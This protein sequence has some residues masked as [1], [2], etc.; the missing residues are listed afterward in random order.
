M[1]P[2]S[3]PTNAHGTITTKEV[4]D[5]VHFWQ[6]RAVGGVEFILAKP[7]VIERGILRIDLLDQVVELVLIMEFE[8]DGQGD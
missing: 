2:F 8:P 4:C 6:R 7:F 5:S 3:A 1:V